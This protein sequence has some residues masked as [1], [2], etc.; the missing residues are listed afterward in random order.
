MG[1]CQNRGPFL[2]TLNNR[3]RIILGTQKGTIILTTTHMYFI[4]YEPGIMRGVG[5]LRQGLLQILRGLRM[6]EHWWILTRAII[7]VTT[8]M[9]FIL[10]I[11][12]TH[13]C[14]NNGNNNT[15]NNNCSYQ[16]NL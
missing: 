7:I 5:S 16:F 15:N 9:Q 13:H 2:G 3:C 6:E 8:M 14:N 11:I 10:V 12:V 1:S 4:S